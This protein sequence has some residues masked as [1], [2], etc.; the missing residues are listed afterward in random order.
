M[1]PPADIDQQIA[2]LVKLAC[3]VPT[4]VVRVRE[5]ARLRIAALYVDEGRRRSATLTEASIAFRASYEHRATAAQRASLVEAAKLYRRGRKA[6]QEVH[7]SARSVLAGLTR[8]QKTVFK[9]KSVLPADLFDIATG[10]PCPIEAFER[11]CEASSPQDDFIE[12]EVAFNKKMIPERIPPNIQTLLWWRCYV[13]KYRGKWV[14]MQ[15]L[16]QAW[17]VSNISDRSNFRANV[18]SLMK[19]KK[20]RLLTGCPPW[21]LP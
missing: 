3:D 10:T 20:S 11:L 21:A 4:D 8:F 15:A 7:A 2:T 1:Q 19:M 9:N 14:D 12:K 5:Y 18:E 6:S 16:A 13:G 17:C